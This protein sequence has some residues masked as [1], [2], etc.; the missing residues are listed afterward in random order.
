MCLFPWCHNHESKL[1]L[2]VPSEFSE[3]LFVS[4]NS[5]N[6]YLILDNHIK[7]EKKVST[8]QKKGSRDPGVPS[9]DT[10]FKIVKTALNLTRNSLKFK[11]LNT[12]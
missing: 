6:K 11:N 10:D 5:E 7:T 8:D 2:L 3:E 1:M 9:T 4:K 12:V